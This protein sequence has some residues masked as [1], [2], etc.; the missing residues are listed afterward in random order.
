MKNTLLHQAA[1]FKL[2]NR[3]H[4][5]WQK[6]VSIL[7]CIV[8]FCTVYAL[9][10]PALTAEGTPHCGIEE[11][12]H[13]DEC[14]ENRLICGK[15][16]G[17]GAHTHTDECYTQ[18]QTLICGLEE[19]EGAHTHTEECYDE[20]GNLICGL[21]ENEGHQHTEECYQTENILTCDQEESEGH[22]HTAECYEQVLACGKEEH[23]HSLACY[24]DPNADVEDADT[25]QNSVSSVSLT[26]NWGSDLAA[27]A[28]T[29]IGYRESTSN[30]N[31][32]EDGAT[33]NGY[34]RYGA[35]A[36]A[37]YRDNWSAQFTDFCLSYAGIPSSAMVQPSDCWEWAPVSK[38]GYTPNT[39][40][41]IIL[42]GNQDG[43]PDHAG[44]V[45]NAND[46]QVTTVIGDSDKEVKQNTYNLDN[47]IIVGYVTMPRNPNFDY[48]DAEPAVDDADAPEPDNN[49]IEETPTAE[50][51][52]EPA[53]AA[54]EDEDDAPEAL[55]DETSFAG[56]T[57]EDGDSADIATQGVDFGAYI[58]NVTF[59]CQES[60]SGIWETV[61][62]GETIDKGDKIRFNLSYTLP[63]GTL[64]NGENSISYTLPKALKDFQDS[65]SVYNNSEKEIGSYKIENGVV[66]IT[67]DSEFANSNKNSDIEGWVRL[68]GL[69][70]EVITD[71]DGKADFS[72]NDKFKY[73]ITIEKDLNEKG[74]LTVQKSASNIDQEKGTLSY[75]ITVS[76]QHGT[77]K[78]VT[79][80][81][82]MTNI[83]PDGEFTVKDKDGKVIKNYPMTRTENGF[84][85]KLPKMNV[86]DIYTITYNAKL[87]DDAK[88]TV[89]A[90]N[91]IKASSTRSDGSKLEPEQEITTDFNNKV[92][93]KGV[94]SEDGK[95]VTWTVTINPRKKDLNGWTL[96]DKLN[97]QEY[98]GT[99]KID[100]PVKDSDGNS[101]SEIKLPYTFGKEDNA[102]YTITY[103][104][105]RK[106]G[107]VKE[108]NE[109]IMT[110]P[111]DSNNGQE[112]SGEIGVDIK[113]TYTKTGTGASGNPDGTITLNWTL[114]VNAMTEISMNGKEAWWFEDNTSDGQWFTEAQITDLR[115]QLDGVSLGG[116]ALKGN[117]TLTFYPENSSDGKYTRVR[118]VSSLPVPAD[119][120][121]DITFSTTAVKPANTTIYYNGMHFNNDYIQGQNKY[122]P[123]DA[124]VEKVDF[125]NQNGGDETD[126]EY[127]ESVLGEN[128]TLKWRIK[129]TI[130]GRDN[131]IIIVE[132]LPENVTLTKLEVSAGGKE[133]GPWLGNN[134][135]NLSGNTTIS[136][137]D[138]DLHQ[139]VISTV[140]VETD[141]KQQI[142]ITVPKD[143]IPD[144]NAP[145]ASGYGMT[146]TVFLDVTVKI[147]DDFSGWIQD[148]GA[149]LKYARFQN[150]VEVTD[151]QG[152][153]LGSDDQTQKITFDDNYNVI[154]KYT[155][156]EVSGNCTITYRVEI[157]PNAAD[158]L[159][160]GDE[161]TL[162]D[163]LTY[164]Y[165][166][167]NQQK[168]T[169]VPDSVIV[170]EK[171]G[172]N[173][174]ELNKNEY[175][176]IYSEVSNPQGNSE[177]ERI[178]TLKFTIP[179]SKSLVVEYKYK[180][181]GVEGKCTEPISN[182]ATLEGVSGNNSS[183][184][185][186]NSF[187]IKSSSAGADTTGLTIYKVDSNNYGKYLNGA[188]FTLYKYANGQW[189]EVEKY[190]SNKIQGVDG[191][192]SVK[193]LEKKVAYKLVETKAPSGYELPDNPEN[194]FYLEEE[195]TEK[196]D[197]FVGKK[198][199]GGT[200][201]YYPNTKSDKYELPETGGIGTNRFTAVGLAL[202]AGS[203]MCGYV[204][205]R[206]R[207]E[208]REI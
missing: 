65:G 1:K 186:K 127:H 26:G 168:V 73:D 5:R 208:R 202:M 138:G 54:E 60:G 27:I 162:T 194:Y 119:E 53:Q 190:T 152:N 122:V 181:T 13:T 201:I 21:E 193:N 155:V 159:P 34:T 187:E 120:H 38:E 207:R 176:Y 170:Y 94:L 189:I 84:T 22:Q 8:V 130:P 164:Q 72:F 24:S 140:K 165:K 46:T 49:N 184:S 156:G 80:E 108:T 102:T 143:L 92:E 18:E 135:L 112:S 52:P 33:M 196:P 93:K 117:Y 4:K 149:S 6:A 173:L 113:N 147:N 178:N 139:N 166:T 171:T 123:T 96:R 74:D 150:S 124:S 151:S 132:K 144:L 29:Q 59:E 55:D 145:F 42:D 86:G 50:E 45:L 109:A 44:I 41:L 56:V 107:S 9:I 99:V 36:G 141:A 78:D 57:G 167:H 15:E 3:K 51:T 67:F 157:N 163:V 182:T 58:T 204:M 203:L 199:Y 183:N 37:P 81:D 69:A 35:W 142:K 154:K 12:T 87:P 195:P 134:S 63:Q 2:Q 47:A 20:D 160:N 104:T 131:D 169:L 133:G 64:S 153:E 88:Y 188:E 10:L 75:T 158:L 97:G 179:D 191:M 177:E 110:P 103:T 100:P 25:W 206:K 48:G 197:G 23:A 28:Q 106:S 205:R 129:A 192:F 98:V 61:K 148:S 30:Y 85:G 76:S 66:T 121:F 79:L 70:S 17:E 161:L 118:V 136:R 115:K 125:N 200:Q 40:D 77:S 82:I 14:Y 91:K 174:T 126:H 90:K 146:S 71:K 172:E 89:T 43:T 7:A 114:S 39:G 198:V 101:S 62:N 116:K 105:D 111:D 83:V 175:S 11:H 128:G 137:W 32:A 68:S 185:N 16:E 19:G 180:V 95:T 31:V